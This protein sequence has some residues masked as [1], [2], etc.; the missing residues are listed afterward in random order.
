MF[1][2]FFTLIKC[3]LCLLDTFKIMLTEFC[4]S[5]Y[6]VLILKIK[7]FNLFQNFNLLKTWQ[8]LKSYKNNVEYLVQFIQLQ[9]CHEVYYFLFPESKILKNVEIDSNSH[10]LQDTFAL[11]AAASAKAKTTNKVFIFQFL[12]FGPKHQKQ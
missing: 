11:A 6:F 4:R 7:G 12:L 8:N 5:S 9:V 10:P 3:S 1:M 2:F